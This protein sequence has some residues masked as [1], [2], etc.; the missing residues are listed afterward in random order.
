[1]YALLYLGSWTW[2]ATYPSWLNKTLAN[3]HPAQTI[4][5]ARSALVGTSVLSSYSNLDDDL[6][7]P[8]ECEENLLSLTEGR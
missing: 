4:L 7:K 1:M 6:T 3:Y 5:A 2:M 8:D